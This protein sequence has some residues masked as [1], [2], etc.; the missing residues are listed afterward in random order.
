MGGMTQWL[1]CWISYWWMVCQT[2]GWVQSVFCCFFEQQ[3][4]HMLLDTG[5][6]QEQIQ[7]KIPW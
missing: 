1:A 3:A 2:G 5:L 4:L 7:A 6:L